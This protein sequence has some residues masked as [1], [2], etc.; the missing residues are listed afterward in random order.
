MVPFL[1]W[2]KVI[3]VFYDGKINWLL[4]TSTSRTHNASRASLYWNLVSMLH[5]CSDPHPPSD[6]SISL[7]DFTQRK[8]SLSAVKAIF[9]ASVLSEKY[10]ILHSRHYTRLIIITMNFFQLMNA[11][12][13]FLHVGFLPLLYRE[14]VFVTFERPPPPPSD[15]CISAN[16]STLGNEINKMIEN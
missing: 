11:A 15:P 14:K 10:I 7:P 2:A 12:V 4:W 13:L 5:Q 1:L 8:L 3:F 6:N 16:M 9:L